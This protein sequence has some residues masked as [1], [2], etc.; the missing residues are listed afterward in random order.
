MLRKTSVFV[1]V[2]LFVG[3]SIVSGLNT[4]SNSNSKPINRDWLYVGG[5][6]SGNYSTIQSA[7]DAASAGDTI[8][9]YNGTYYECIIINKSINLF[10]IDKNTTIIDG[11]G[12]GNVVN[13][14]ADLVNISGFTIQNTSGY[15]FD[16]AGIFI[17]S[18]YNTI[19][20]NIIT[21]N[22]DG[23]VLSDDSNTN[24]ISSNIIISNNYDGILL[25]YSNQNNII[26]N[27][28]TNPVFGIYL[29]NS[30]YNNINNNVI[31]NNSQCGI[32]LD[33]HPDY[34][35]DYNTFSGN[36]IINNSCGIE[37]LGDNNTVYYNNFINNTINAQDSGTNF[38]YNSS[39][40]EGNYWSDYIGEDNN[41][42][43]IGDIPYNITGGSNQD[44]YPLMHPF[45][46]YYVL[47][48]IPENTTVNESTVF[49]V[50]V[51][52][53]GGTCIPDALV[54]FNDELKQTDSN[55]V[56]N[57]TA[58]QVENDTYYEIIA[59][60]EDYTGANKTILVKNVQNWVSNVIMF[61]L[62]TNLTTAEENI[63][64]NAKFVCVLEF[65]PFSVK[66]YNLG[67]K[68]II[69]K[70]YRGLVGYRFIFTACDVLI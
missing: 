50:T 1:L 9:V 19:F 41:G 25:A 62:I 35:S 52:S 66:I 16:Y 6:G 26:Y 63:Q 61:G 24:T 47:D 56:V 69:S 43:G 45:E 29:F 7:I 68:F 15:Y 67:Q 21:N 3:A 44:L 11:G 70:N 33:N 60:K 8:F 17:D 22:D 58:P 53:L 64:F 42:D 38:W 49:N 55:G 4:I 12:I 54:E 34:P 57:F 30:S 51:K 13:I 65:S 28:I 10:G 40:K 5:S 59:T 2:V 23:I 48:V 37:L 31:Q 14:T 46:N 20:N 27:T 32:F 18:Y 39:L 36:I